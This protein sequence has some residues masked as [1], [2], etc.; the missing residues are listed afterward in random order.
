VNV[1]GVAS[2]NGSGSAQAGASGA[3][4]AADHPGGTERLLASSAMLGRAVV[5]LNATVLVLHPPPVR[6][7]PDLRVQQMAAYDRA[8][9]RALAMADRNPSQRAARDRA[10]ASARIQLAAATRRRLNPAASLASMPC[11]ACLQATRD[12]ALNRSRTDLFGRSVHV[13]ILS[14]IDYTLRPGAAGGTSV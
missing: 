5:A 13:G 11:S 2:A 8:M 14:V 7:A 10:I 6:A 1:G 3:T 12:S 4:G 9:L